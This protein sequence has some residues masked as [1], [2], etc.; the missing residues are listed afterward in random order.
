MLTNRRRLIGCLSLALALMIVLVVRIA[1]AQPAPQQEAVPIGDTTL[2]LQT[3]RVAVWQEGDC[4]TIH[5]QI[6]GIRAIYWLNNPTTGINS[7]RWCIRR[8][9]DVPYFM[10]RLR[11]GT[12]INTPAFG[13]HTVNT[14]IVIA[15]LP[16]LLLC[17]WCFRLPHLLAHAFDHLPTALRS[18]FAV[19]GRVQPLLV[20]LFVIVNAIVVWNVIHQQSAA[21]YDSEGHY[22]NVAVIAQGRLPTL[23]DSGEFFSPPLPYL[24]PALV[25]RVSQTCLTPNQNCFEGI[26]KLG[27][28]QNVVV[29]V[30][31]IFFL[32]RLGQQLQPDEATLRTLALLLLAMLPVYYK[33]FSFMR[34]EP[35]VVLFTLLLIDRLLI[36][37]QRPPGW[38]DA[39]SLGTFG[40][41]LLLSRQWGIFI[42]IGVALWWVLLLVKRRQTGLRLIV[43]GLAA[44]LIAL[45]LGGW[46]YLGLLV[47]S[48]TMLA[49]NRPADTAPKPITFFTG[50]G[51]SNLFTYPFSPGYDGQALPIFYT[52]IWGDYFGYFYLQ[53][54]VVA[55]RYPASVL[56]YMGR[57]NAL[58]LLPTLLLLIGLVYGIY[59]LIRS[60]A[61]TLDDKALIVSLLTSV[62]LIS[63]VGFIWFLARYPSGDADTAKATYLLQ[64]F[65]CLCLLTAV[66]LTVIRR[67]WPILFNVLV[68]LLIVVAVHN[69][70]MY[71]SRMN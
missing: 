8:Q 15:V 50:L 62:T 1:V 17:A 42:L 64:I 38:L 45:I 23:A 32:L 41:L 5:W 68:L 3:D 44:S 18:P 31:T 58:S 46:F 19:E 35:F 55:V 9:V 52:E 28:A 4:V 12:E 13:Y 40:G 10:I 14:E 59:R 22:A 49:F 11:D 51:G 65:P 54:P 2:F 33:T 24:L 21:A 67:R 60:L 25:A 69:D 20:A 53:R 34:G 30:V 27:Q 36:L 71:F 66:W 16:L 70:L 48:G 61:T 39:V 47:N 29:S 6:E 43:P 63:I 26:R 56:S 37:L 57:V 7:A